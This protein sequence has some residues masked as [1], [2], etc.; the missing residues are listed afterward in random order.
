MSNQKELLDENKLIH[1]LFTTTAVIVVLNIVNFSFNKPSWLLDTLINVNRESSFPTW[2]SSA[3]W[4]IA[5]YLAY[6][7][8]RILTGNRASR[9]TLLFFS[10]L[11]LLFSCDEVASLHEN[12]NA[13][14]SMHF[15]FGKNWVEALLPFILG[16]SIFLAIRLYKTLNSH[17]KAMFLIFIGL[18]L[19]I[20]GAVILEYT[21]QIP[22]P[23]K[24]MMLYRNIEYILEEGFE[25]LGAILI[26]KGLQEHYKFLAIQ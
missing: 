17:K 7:C 24:T 19:V 16:A 14:T 11:L 9:R 20:F 12:S 22:S 15:H 2:F 5:A 25:M 3:L 26:I 6:R 8:Y 10:L 4:L 1:W 13:I 23:L 18:G 21:I